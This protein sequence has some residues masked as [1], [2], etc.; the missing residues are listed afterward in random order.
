MIHNH[1]K[2]RWVVR[3]AVYLHVGKQQGRSLVLNSGLK[4]ESF[5]KIVV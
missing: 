5:L 3:R 1:T 4:E 2:A